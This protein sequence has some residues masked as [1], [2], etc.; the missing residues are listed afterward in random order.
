MAL[1]A[2]RSVLPYHTPVVQGGVADV[3]IKSI[4]RFL[5]AVAAHPAVARLLGKDRR[6]LNL[7]YGSVASFNRQTRAPYLRGK[8]AVNLN[9]HGGNQLPS[10][11]GG[12]VV[13]HTVAECRE[14]ALHCKQ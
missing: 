13:L 8:P 12:V 10:L 11:G 14:R 9:L 6:S 4:L 3:T 1:D 2:R 5:T 7:G